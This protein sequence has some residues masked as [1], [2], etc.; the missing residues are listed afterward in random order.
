VSALERASVTTAPE[1]CG[2][3]LDD[4]GNGIADEGCGTTTSAVSFLVAWDEPTADVDLRVVD[5]NG[6]LVEV[7]R[8]TES[9]LVRE[10]DCPGRD[11]ECRGKN[12]ESV[13]QEQGEPAP[14]KYV[15][16]ILLVSLGGSEPPIVVRFAARLGTESF[17]AT[18]RLP[19]VESDWQMVFTL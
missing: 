8:P 1:V 12:L 17:G 14:G 19:R 2:N 7:G 10:R 15:A 6:E 16:R 9:G 13:Y 3:A 11:G 4:N 18:V 5:P